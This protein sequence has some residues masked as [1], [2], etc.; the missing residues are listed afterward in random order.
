MLSNHAIRVDNYAHAVEKEEAI[1][2]LKG[3][4]KY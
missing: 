2:I 4:N 3:Y 1:K